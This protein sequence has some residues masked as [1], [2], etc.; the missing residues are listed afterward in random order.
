MYLIIYK[1]YRIVHKCWKWEM[2]Y[3]LYIIIKQFIVYV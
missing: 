2:P 3:T 1:W